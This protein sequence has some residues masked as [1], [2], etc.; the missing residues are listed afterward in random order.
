MI[1]ST[2]IHIYMYICPY[3][4]SNENLSLKLGKYKAKYFSFDI[5]ACI[6]DKIKWSKNIMIVC[7]LK[8][9]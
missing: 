6:C 2:N 9:R 8:A 1:M 4:F 5:S 3:L 7:Y